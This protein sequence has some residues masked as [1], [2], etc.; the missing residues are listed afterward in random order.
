MPELIIGDTLVSKNSELLKRR[1][2]AVPAGVGNIHPVFADRAENAEIFDVDGKRY[3]D[4]AA[5]IAVVNTGHLHPKVKQAVKDQL[6]KFS[7]TCFHVAMY[8]N[9]VRLAER[10]NELAP[11]DTAKK[12]MFVTTG[13]E[14]VENAIKVARSYT[15][16]SGIV[17]FSG[18]FHGRTLLAL[19]M[20][21]K[22]VPYK[23]GFGPMPAE[24]YHAPYPNPLYGISSA[25]AL[26]GVEKLFKSDIEPKRVAAFMIEPVQGEGG[27]YIAPPEFMQ[28]LR[29]LADEHGILLI[30]DEV[31]TGFARTGKMFATEYSGIEPDMMTMAKGLAGGFPLAAL[32]GKA[33]IMDAVSPGGVGGTYAGNPLGCA[34][35]LAVLDVISEE[36]LTGKAIEQGA[37]LQ[38][39][40]KAMAEKVDF[41][42]DV[43]GLGAMVAFE[44]FDDVASLTPAPEKTKALLEKAREKG[45]L[46]LSCG[47]N[48]NVIR[49][50]APLTI[51]RELLDEGLAIIEEC[52]S[53]L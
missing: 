27:F 7:H 4:F 1:A 14:A 32:T 31:Q 25:D 22:V 47:N 13:A 46:L 41:I 10:I 40:L 37:H 21:G 15:G 2:A 39:R 34:A 53:E 30:S 20:T 36:N 52:L 26:A 6:E 3:I 17:A 35:A 48:A 50:L 18:G 29:K 33:E 23:A 5:G 45:L 16:R 11:G 44:L 51:E 24:V 9:Y 12:T 42:G 38:N 8:E 43:R 49:M 19:S 28:G